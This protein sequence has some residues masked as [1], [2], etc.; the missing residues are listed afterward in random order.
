MRLDHYLPFEKKRGLIRRALRKMGPAWLSA[1]LRRSIQ[2]ACFALFCLF[3]FYICWPYSTEPDADVAGWPSHYAD[4]LAAREWVDAES[5]LALDPLLSISTAIASRMWI[6]SL[7]WAAAVLGIGI[8]I[9]RGFCGYICPLGT[10]IDLFDWTIGKRV[11][12]FQIK[13]RGRWVHLKYYLLAGVLV[14]ALFG[15]L[16]SGFVAAI[17]VVTRGFTFVLAPLQLGLARG[18]YQV[19]PMNA[20]HL[21]S[22]LLFLAVLVLG[23]FQPRFWCRYVCPTGALFSLGNLFA[24]VGERKVEGSCIDCG[25]CVKVCPFDAIKADFTTRTMDCTFCQTCAGVCPPGA[26]K[27][28]DRWNAEN[29]KENLPGGEI[30]LSRRGFLAAAAAGLSAAFGVKSLY[31]AHLTTT[32]SSSLPIRP[33]MSVPEEEFLEMCIRCGLC[34]KAC[35]NSVLQPLGFDQGLEGLWTPQVVADWSGC[36]PSCNNC[37]QVCPTGAIRALPIG[38]KRVARIGLAQ[39]EPACLPRA[40]EAACQLC[41]D[42]CRRAGYEAI[43]FE[44]VHPQLDDDGLP[45]EGTGFVA[46]VVIPDSCVGCG[47]CQSACYRINVKGKGL[48]ERSAIIVRTGS[49]REDRILTGTYTELRQQEEKAR[50]GKIKQQFERFDDFY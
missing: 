1:P 32:E 18:W 33:P 50:R 35:P 25:Q 4:D 9:P 24:R 11:K 14:A 38:E 43:E 31:G 47:L 49:G 22:V 48:L 41:V 26:I 8:L 39:V 29:L 3:F 6:W 40:V 21:L 36:E 13:G 34:F 23:L 27:F 16:L 10:L 42:E 30:P 19:P 7:A 5:F 2:T 46:P 20:G 37:G 44:R 17:P 45:I 12:Q 28:V 15:V